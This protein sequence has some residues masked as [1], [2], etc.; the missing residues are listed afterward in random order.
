MKN[1][2]IGCVLAFVAGAVAALTPVAADGIVVAE[3]LQ[4]A[5]AGIAAV[6]A[7]LKASPLQK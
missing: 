4:A 6:F 3:L 5:G 7:Y 1:I 2:V